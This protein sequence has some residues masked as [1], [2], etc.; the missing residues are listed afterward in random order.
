[1]SCHG[2]GKWARA[3][4]QGDL[5]SPFRVLPEGLFQPSEFL[6]RLSSFVYVAPRRRLMD[7]WAAYLRG[8]REHVVADADNHTSPGGLDPVS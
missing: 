2:A 5:L 1:M 6:R 3:V 8:A 7:D 4:R